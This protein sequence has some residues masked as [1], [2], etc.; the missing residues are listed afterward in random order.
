M[1]EPPAEGMCDRPRDWGLWLAVLTKEGINMRVLTVGLSALVCTVAL[2]AMATSATAE[3]RGQRNW[4][5]A[6]ESGWRESH[7]GY[8]YRRY[9]GPRLLRGVLL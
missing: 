6:E 4:N 8:G 1:R 3:Q 7:R 9:D 2:L 5:K